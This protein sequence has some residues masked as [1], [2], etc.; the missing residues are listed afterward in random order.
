MVD[1]MEEKIVQQIVMVPRRHKLEKKLTCA[2]IILIFN[3]LKIIMSELVK[4]IDRDGFI[5]ELNLS[6]IKS[7]IQ[8]DRFLSSIKGV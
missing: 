8:D 1:I 3:L 7:L 5:A 6:Q 4:E 2:G